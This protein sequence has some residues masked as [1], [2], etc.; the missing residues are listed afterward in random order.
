MYEADGDTSTPDHTTSNSDPDVVQVHL[1]EQESTLSDMNI[2]SPETHDM[3]AP[4]TSSNTGRFAYEHRSSVGQV[5]YPTENPVDTV[6]SSIIVDIED[7][8]R[9]RLLEEVKVDD[10]VGF[11]D[12]DDDDETSEERSNAS[13]IDARYTKYSKPGTL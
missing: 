6:T 12:D 13:M 11:E 7:D 1:A 3:P 5:A 10:I 4:G 9:R 8:V 2:H